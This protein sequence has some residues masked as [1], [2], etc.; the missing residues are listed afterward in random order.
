MRLAKRLWGP[1]TIRRYEAVTVCLSLSR[2][3]GCDSSSCSPDALQ[4]LTLC[5]DALLTAITP[6]SMH[7]PHAKKLAEDGARI[8]PPFYELEKGNSPC[9]RSFGERSST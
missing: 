7:L 9:S 8:R 5:R 1:A 2:G 6:M 3:R 4:V